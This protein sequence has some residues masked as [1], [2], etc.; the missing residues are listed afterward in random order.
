[1]GSPVILPTL[2][3]FLLGI[4]V[5][6]L[7]RLYRLHSHT[8]VIVKQSVE[9]LQNNSSVA[10]S[11]SV[12]ATVAFTKSEPSPKSKSKSQSKTKN[13]STNTTATNIAARSAT[14]AED[15]LSFKEKVDMIGKWAEEIEDAGEF[16]ISLDMGKKRKYMGGLFAERIV[17]EGFR[18]HEKKFRVL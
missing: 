10:T 13:V 9:P 12:P 1:M 8:E 4:V 7:Y 5:S 6:I 15:S 16:T 14:Q 18:A 11:A 2:I 3:A 17:V